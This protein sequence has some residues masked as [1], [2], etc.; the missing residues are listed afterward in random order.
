MSIVIYVLAGLSIVLAIGGLSGYA[1]TKHPGLLLASLVS[2]ASAVLAIVLVDWWPL[3]VG[4]AANWGLRL[5]GMDPGV[6]K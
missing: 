6:R 5:L 3:V 2:I 4:F 1:Q